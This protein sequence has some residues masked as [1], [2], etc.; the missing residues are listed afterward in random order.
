MMECKYIQENNIQAEISLEAVTFIFRISMEG[1]EVKRCRN[2]SISEMA[3]MKNCILFEIGP[4][5]IWYIII[6]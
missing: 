6:A 3:E 2:Q 4:S 5:N 1:Y